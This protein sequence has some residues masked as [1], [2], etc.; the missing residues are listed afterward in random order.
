MTAIRTQGSI[1]KVSTTEAASDTITGITAAS[2]PVVTAASHGISN[3]A[4]V[5]IDSVVGMVQVNNRAFVV[6][7]QATN[8]VELKGVDGTGY[9]AYGSAGAMIAHT[10]TEIGQIT[11]IPSLFD[12]TAAEIEVTHLRST[13]KE[14][15]VGLQDFGSSSFEVTL[16]TTDTGQ[17]KLRALKAAGA[18]G[19]FSLERPDGAITAFRA[20]V[21]SFQTAVAG[22]N[23]YRATI[24]LKHVSEP[25]WFA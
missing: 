18:T 15:D 4:I 19:T 2:P 7:N 11:G 9:T 17:A 3:G 5:S 21:L 10:M 13:A 24:Q 6:A 16:M 8:T 14:F 25:A 1:L 20:K 23:V 12:G 22:D